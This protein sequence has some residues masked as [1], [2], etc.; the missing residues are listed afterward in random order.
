MNI[1]TRR[2]GPASFRP[3][4]RAVVSASCAVPVT[5]T[6][7]ASARI[8]LPGM[9]NENRRVYSVSNAAVICSGGPAGTTSA[10][11]VPS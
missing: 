6:E 7:T 4:E 8:V 5:S 11:S 3:A 1:R 10:V 9:R 2:T